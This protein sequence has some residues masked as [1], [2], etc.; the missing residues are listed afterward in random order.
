MFPFRQCSRIHLS[1]LII[2]VLLRRGCPD[3]ISSPANRSH[4][5]TGSTRSGASSMKS[6]RT[7]PHESTRADSDLLRSKFGRA[8]ARHAGALDGGGK[9]GAGA[10]SSER[11]ARH[12]GTRQRAPGFGGAD[13]GE[14]GER[15]PD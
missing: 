10:V 6:G 2:G 1:D 3:Y 12:A 13:G 7:Y 15:F 8:F 11:K 14:R 4:F 9:T 5:V